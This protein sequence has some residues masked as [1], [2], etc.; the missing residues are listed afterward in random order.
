MLHILCLIL[1]IIGIILLI[2]LG[3]LLFVC[4]VVL[5]Y[6]VSY[7]VAAKADGEIKSLSIEAKASWLLRMVSA[8]ATY[9]EQ[10][11]EWQV[12]LFGWKLNRPEKE[13]QPGVNAEEAKTDFE[14]VYDTKVNIEPK[15]D[16]QREEVHNEET[17]REEKQTNPKKPK[18][19]VKKER[20]SWIEK[21]RCTI[22]KICDKIKAIW[23]LKDEIKNFLTNEIHL[24]AFKKIKD[25][26]VV[27]A[28][29]FRPRRLR[30]RM[31]FGLSDPYNTGQVL[32]GLSV[33]YPFYGE[34]LDVYP[35]FE[36][37][38]LD[39]NVYFQ[40]HI[41]LVHFLRIIWMIFFDI[42]IK[43]TYRHFKKIDFHI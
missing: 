11:F 23:K 17:H 39:G 38:I 15:Q 5:F 36:Q 22:Q 26:V 3:I 25:E 31:R 41:R 27:L 19:K 28:K 35:D 18:T 16:M 33:L 20:Q 6:P 13:E 8:F 37:E 30:G 40:G 42:D 43:K 12:N 2:L 1:K 21:I 24:R 7:R 32:A 29:H 4:G 34:N 14:D 10:K 9:R